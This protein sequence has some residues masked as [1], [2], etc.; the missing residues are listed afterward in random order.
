MPVMDGL[1]ATRSI[2]QAQAAGDPGFAR[3]IRIVA[4]TANAMSGDREVCLAAG[5]D[6]YTS[7]PLTPRG[8]R[9]VLESYL[10]PN[11]PGGSAA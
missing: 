1:E 6:D 3:E 4:M 8:L 11:P 7:K 2:R 5:M 9:L 10:R